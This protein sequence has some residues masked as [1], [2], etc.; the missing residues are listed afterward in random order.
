M[1]SNATPTAKLQVGRAKCGRAG[2]RGERRAENCRVTWTP[3][4]LSRLSLD[5]GL[6][7]L[8]RNQFCRRR[9]ASENSTRRETQ[10]QGRIADQRGATCQVT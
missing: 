4:L 6:K 1:I 2:G 9:I 10:P 3:L 8:Q 5:L 7:R